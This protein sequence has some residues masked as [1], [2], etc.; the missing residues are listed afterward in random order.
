M[1]PVRAQSYVALPAAAPEAKAK[2][3]P[4][5][6]SWNQIMAW[7]RELNMLRNADTG[8]HGPRTHHSDRDRQYTSLAFGR[9]SET[10][11][12]VSDRGV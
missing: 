10:M 3:S 12:S 7:L 5:V 8:L 4:T 2:A 9:R 11:G 1:R 6:P